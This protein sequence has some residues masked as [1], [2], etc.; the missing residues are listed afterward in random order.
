MSE[1]GVETNHRLKRCFLHYF[2]EVF[3]VA[4]GGSSLENGGH[5]AALSRHLVRDVE[6]ARKTGRVSYC[7]GLN[8]R[9][10][11]NAAE[12]TCEAFPEERGLLWKRRRSIQ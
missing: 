6:K 8:A 4:L 5:G 2:H 12:L 7:G 10:S 3:G 1:T 9:S 11:K